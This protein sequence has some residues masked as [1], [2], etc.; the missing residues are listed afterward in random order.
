MPATR[1][2]LLHGKVLGLTAQVENA[3]YRIDGCSCPNRSGYDLILMLS[4]YGCISR[5]L[6]VFSVASLLLCV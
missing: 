4:S 5:Y 6:S 3:W 2:K 1:K